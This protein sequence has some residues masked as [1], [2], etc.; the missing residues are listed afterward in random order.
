M[1][2]YADGETL[3]LA[4]VR[5][6]A[7]YNSENTSRGNW[8]ILNSGKSP[9]YVVLRPGPFEVELQSIGGISGSVATEVTHWQ[10]QLMVYQRYVDDGTTATNIQARVAEIIAQVQKWRRLADTAD[11]IQKAR[12][13]GGSELVE[14]GPEGQVPIWLRWIINVNWD[15]ER[16][17]TFSE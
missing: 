17:I 8:R 4:V 13:V 2:G 12:V 5:L 3:L 10:T 14:L 15:E 11:I 1:S 9:Y 7:N 6:H 16:Q